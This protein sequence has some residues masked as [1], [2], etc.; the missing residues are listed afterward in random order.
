VAGA[1]RLSAT[2]QVP[3]NGLAV[4][5]WFVVVVKGTDGQCAPM[6]PIYPDDI[7]QAPNMTLAQLVDGNLGQGGVLALGATNALYFEP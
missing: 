5:T 3:F 1:D 6:F 2:L 7:T 4:D